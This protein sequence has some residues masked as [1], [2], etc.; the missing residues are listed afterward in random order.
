MVVVASW[1]Y[2]VL[3]ST[4]AW[5]ESR[6]VVNKIKMFETTL[7]L[8]GD[9][10]AILNNEAVVEGGG[11]WPG[12]DYVV[13]SRVLDE[14]LRVIIET[15]GMD[16]LLPPSEFPPPI[17]LRADVDNR[18]VRYEQAPNGRSYFLM[19]AWLRDI[20]E[21]GPQRLIQ[22]AMDETGERAA[23]ASHRRDTILGLA[24][25]VL[26]FALV[27]KYIATRCLQPV[28]SLARQAERIST[29]NFISKVDPATSRWPMELT[30]LADSFYRMLERI[31]SSFRRL[32][33]CTD[34]MAHE[35]RNPIS[36]LMGETEV[37]LSKDR[38][39][40]EYRQVLES[41][42]EECSRLSRMIKELLF[43]AGADNPC[44]AVKRT[45]L[46]VQDELAAVLDFH[47]S[48]AQEQGILI[49]CTGKATLNADPTMLRRAISNLVSNA[50]S[51]TP[52]GGEITLVAQE[53]HDENV[54]E[55]LVC[56][57]GCGIEEKD[58]AR[59]F[60]RFHRGKKRDPNQGDGTGLG[61]AI[62]KSIM[63]LHG[64]AVSIDS[65][66]NGGTTVTLRFPSEI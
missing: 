61:L 37:A 21:E 17:V 43:V 52:Q 13:Y 4:L 20:G 10:M 22:V 65:S 23:I 53:N 34:D 35:L 48:Q 38:T 47:E 3:T 49:T 27:G 5:D 55:I 59:V 15:P 42:L 32:S 64:G 44:N 62:V 30:T 57:T 46:T 66:V 12:Q 9:N 60:D 11:Y 1:L 54:V 7:R 25:A 36:R 63:S 19:A 56:D 2:W 40:A 45:R 18:A 8:E 50:L 51:H 39:P 58:L 14:S 28:H 24:F 31:D 33:Q 26:A 16:Q 41:N 29:S 6:L